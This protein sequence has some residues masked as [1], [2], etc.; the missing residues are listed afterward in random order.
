MT[1]RDADDTIRPLVTRLAPP[2]GSSLE[3]L[4]ARLDRLEIAFEGLQVALDRHEVLQDMSDQ[5]A[6]ARFRQAQHQRL[7]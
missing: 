1:E 4:N 3:S 6:E 7:I 2:H 5:R